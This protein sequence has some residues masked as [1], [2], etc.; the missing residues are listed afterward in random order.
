VVYTALLVV[1]A[2]WDVRERRIPNRL[3]GII[4]VLGLVYTVIQA[5]GAQG[6]LRGGAGMGVGL[7]CWLPFYFLGWLGAGDVKLFGAA[8]AWLGPPRAVEGAVIAALAGA[9]LAI[10]WMFK[11]QGMKNA[12]NT[13]GLAAGTPELL[14]PRGSSRKGSV[15]PYGI[16]IAFGA[17]WAAWMPSILNR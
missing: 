3:V 4:A 12:V 11:S 7:L 17:I 6:L 5:P 16:A 9:L 8:G 14:S 13:L 10:I 2:V 15:L 1:A